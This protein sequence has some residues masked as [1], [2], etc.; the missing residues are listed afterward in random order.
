MRASLL[1]VGVLWIGAVG[2]IGRGQNL[3]PDLG[4]KLEHAAIAEQM[5]QSCTAASPALA[6]AFATGW[7]DWQLRNKEVVQAV[8]A[9]TKIMETPTGAA[10]IYLFNSLKESLKGQNRISDIGSTEATLMCQHVLS[11]LTK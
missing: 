11:E 1:A 4:E 7:R 10:I 8:E 5:V 9:T 2:S 6:E 3:P